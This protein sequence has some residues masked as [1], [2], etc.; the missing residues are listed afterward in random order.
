MSSGLPVFDTTLQETNLWLKEVESHLAQCG[1]QEAYAATRAVLHV[2]RDRLA[3]EAAL[4][5]SAQLPLLLRGV[6][7]EGWTLSNKPVRLRTVKAF[8]DAVRKRLPPRFRFDP[9]MA[10]HAVMKA[11]ITFNGRKQARKVFAQLPPE[12]APLW[13]ETKAGIDLM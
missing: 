3:P 8:S 4:N 11:V 1:R 9:V 2:L 7:F 13:P 6:F 10:T 12:L 5:F